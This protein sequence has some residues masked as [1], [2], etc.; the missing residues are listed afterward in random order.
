MEERYSFHSGTPF[1]E[2]CEYVR[3]VFF[4]KM[5][6]EVWAIGRFPPIT[7]KNEADRFMMTDML[8]GDEILTVLVEHAPQGGCYVTAMFRLRNANKIAM[9]CVAT[10]VT[11]GLG[12]LIAGPFLYFDYRGWKK[13]WHAA[14]A[15]LKSDFCPDH[16]S[17]RL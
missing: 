4:K 11:C 15:I 2:A 14:V 6:A 17:I 12:A 9:G 13:H 10:L 3:S 5:R 7:N 8:K 1:P 16:P